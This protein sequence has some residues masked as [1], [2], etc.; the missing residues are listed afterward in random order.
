MDIKLADNKTI[1]PPKHFNK[2]MKTLSLEYT[3]V[4]HWNEPNLLKVSK[5]YDQKEMNLV[6]EESE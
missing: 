6:E 2:N 4:K 5:S 1:R 3:P